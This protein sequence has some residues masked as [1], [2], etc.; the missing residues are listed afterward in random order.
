VTEHQTKSTERV[1][2]HGEV[3]TNKREVDAMLDL[4][5]HE[6]ERIDSR[7]LEPACGTGNFL[8]E[9]LSRKLTIVKA[10]YQKDQ[11]DYERYAVIAVSSIYGIDILEDNVEACR[12]RLFGIFMNQYTSLYKEKTK[13]ECQKVVHYILEKNIIWGDA[14]SLKTVCGEAHP[15]IFSE[16]SP[17][18]GDKVKRRDFSFR[19]LM[20]EAEIK[21]MPL[22]SDMGE[23]VY[24]PTP[25][26]DY[27]LKS[28]LRL[29]EL[30]E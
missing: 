15:I 3:Y 7:V 27:P 25:I 28:F 8:A 4:V 22:F 9:V 16:W 11:F 6:M 30:D 21:A 10:R 23:E 29:H 24:L 12:E 26:K 14:L 17:V 5:S 20:S 1:K 2:N 18:N 19:E 13:D